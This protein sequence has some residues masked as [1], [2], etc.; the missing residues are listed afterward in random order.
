MFLPTSSQ[1]FSRL[2]KLI[3][4]WWPSGFGEQ[5]LYD[6]HVAFIPSD[7]NETYIKHLKIG[8]RT[9]ELVEENT[10]ELPGQRYVRNKAS[11]KYWVAFN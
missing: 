9:I 3:N 6:L 4:R 5:W 2:Q 11:R 10:S 8:F 1:F 7:S